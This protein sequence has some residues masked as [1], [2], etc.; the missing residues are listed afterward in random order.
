MLLIK[1]KKNIYKIQKYRIK[2]YFLI[3]YLNK[4]LS[5]KNFNKKYFLNKKKQFFFL[6]KNNINFRFFLKKINYFFKNF[7]FLN[8]IINKFIIQYQNTLKKKYIFI[9][10]NK[11]LLYLI[12]NNIF[13]K[14][15]HLIINLTLKKKNFVLAAI[16]KPTMKI[17][18]Q[19]SAGTNTTIIK[20]K[21]RDIYNIYNQIINFIKKIKIYDYFFFI[22]QVKKHNYLRKRILKF[23]IENFLNLLKKDL[24]LFYF[25][26]QKYYIPIFFLNLFQN[27]ILK[28]Q[29]IQY[30]LINLLRKNNKNLLFFFI[31]KYIIFLNIAHNGCRIKKQPKK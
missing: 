29:I 7:N 31:Y 16:D 24:Y 5:K 28:S 26:L 17:L 12:R 19:I 23:L 8:K 21:R 6:F 18:Y 27:N 9:N 2:N 22:I 3:F 4:F 13:L 30:F 15:K 10:F 25:I 1:N 14:K 20:A 11:N